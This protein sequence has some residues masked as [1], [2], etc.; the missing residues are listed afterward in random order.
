MYC[1]YFQIFDRTYPM[2][3]GLDRPFSIL[4]VSE[5]SYMYSEDT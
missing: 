4:Y 3:V 5:V 2:H 1:T